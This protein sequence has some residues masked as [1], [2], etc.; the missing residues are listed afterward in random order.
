PG[1][2]SRRTL[3]RRALSGGPHGRVSAAEAPLERGGSRGAHAISR[4]PHAI[5]RHP[6]AASGATKD[7]R[8]VRLTA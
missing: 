6:H 1:R 8:A 4:H 2:S 5:S 7:V 3:D